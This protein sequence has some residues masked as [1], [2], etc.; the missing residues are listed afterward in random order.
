MWHTA[1]AASTGVVCDVVTSVRMLQQHNDNRQYTTC[2]STSS[3][4]GREC[5]TTREKNPRKYTLP[6]V[7]INISRAT[8][9]TIKP[10]PYFSLQYTQPAR[11]DGTGIVYYC[12]LR[13]I[14][15]VYYV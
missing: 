3:I 4:T 8:T 2:G 11:Q 5:R 12:L 6:A 13:S 9:Q 10:P 7:V 1:A 14:L 15:H